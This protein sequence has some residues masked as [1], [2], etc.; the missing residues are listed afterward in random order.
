MMITMFIIC[1]RTLCAKSGGQVVT[2]FGSYSDDGASAAYINGVSYRGSSEMSQ[3]WV[4]GSHYL[5]A[6][7]YC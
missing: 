7:G 4:Q 2:L 5:T 3:I 6:I 1:Y